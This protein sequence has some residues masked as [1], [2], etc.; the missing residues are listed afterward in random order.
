VPSYEAEIRPILQEGCIPCHNSPSEGGIAYPSETSYL[1]VS[2][3]VGSM[4][5]Q[6]GPSLCAMPPPTGPQL[7][8]AQRIALEEWLSCGGPDN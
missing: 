7:S 3:Q 1:D 8:T 4:L 2:S 6:V 5:D